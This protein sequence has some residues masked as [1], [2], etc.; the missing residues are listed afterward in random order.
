MYEEELHAPAE[1]CGR[2]RTEWIRMDDIS[3]EVAAAAATSTRQAA[4]A[5]RS[6]RQ[7]VHL[8]R[9]RIPPGTRYTESSTNVPEFPSKHE[10]K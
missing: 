9:P 7:E 2:A 5:A 3:S 8:Y 10:V 1:F 4:A 6:S